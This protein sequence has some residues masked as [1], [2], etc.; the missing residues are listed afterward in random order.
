MSDAPG[1]PVE[2]G[3]TF[4]IDTINNYAL[5]IKKEHKQGTAAFVFATGPLV[6]A[7]DLTTAVLFFSL[8]VTFAVVEVGTEAGG[9]P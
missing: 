8:S 7:V 9:R 3:E 4:P 2:Y 1:I 6:G 5:E